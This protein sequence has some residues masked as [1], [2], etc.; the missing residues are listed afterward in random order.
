MIFAADT[1]VLSLPFLLGGNRIGVCSPVV[2]P[3]HLDALTLG[4]AT[5]LVA[6]LE[7]RKRCDGNCR[8]DEAV[9]VALPPVPVVTA[10]ELG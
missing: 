7:S 4:A 5:K 1:L 6:G 9:V 8:V 10:A 3:A 2:L